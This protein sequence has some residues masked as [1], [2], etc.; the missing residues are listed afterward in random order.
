FNP[1]G[2]DWEFVRLAATPDGRTEIK[3][4]GKGEVTNALGSCQGCHKALAQHYDLVCGFVVGASGLGLTEEQLANLQA[5]DP[6][7]Q[8]KY[9]R[10]RS[11]TRRAT[12]GALLP[13]RPPRTPARRQTEGPWPKQPPGS[14]S[15]RPSS[16]S[17]RARRHFPAAASVRGRR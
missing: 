6:P 9:R 16:T 14:T 10:P 2:D 3:A 1:E 13:S 12:R 4:H 17:T 11:A 8:K 15:R 7:C 5:S